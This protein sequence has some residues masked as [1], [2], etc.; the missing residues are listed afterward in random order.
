MPVGTAITIVA[1]VKY[2]LVFTSMPVGEH[3]VRPDD[4][5][6]H[7]DRD[8]RIG[9]AEIAEHR[10]AAEGR[11]HLADHAEARQDHDVD[12][13]VA[14]EPEQMLVEHR[15]A[16]ARGVEEGRAE[17]AV[18]QQHGDRRRRAPAARA[19]AGTR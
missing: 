9:H 12:L 10:L 2:I 11:D 4:E 13:G 14:E 16:A 17:I 7:A 3:V 15:I 1:A 19:A 8:H 5:A 6:D 18:G